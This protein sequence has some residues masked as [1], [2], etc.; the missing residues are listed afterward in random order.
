M[1]I[2]EYV[3]CPGANG[4]FLHLQFVITYSQ[5]IINIPTRRVI[6]WHI[7]LDSQFGNIRN[8]KNF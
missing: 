4:S 2:V 8:E 7:N 5:N 6:E 1:D 3:I